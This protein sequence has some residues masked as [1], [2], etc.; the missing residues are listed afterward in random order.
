MNCA[1]SKNLLLDVLYE[2]ASSSVRKSV[3]THLTFCP[4]CRQEMS[5]VVE[6]RSIF[7]KLPS[8]EPA[9]HLLENVLAL[10]RIIFPVREMRKEGGWSRFLQIFSVFGL[11]P[12]PLT[13]AGG[14]VLAMIVLFDS[15]RSPLSI[16][17]E[18]KRANF[19]V[20]EGPSGLFVADEAALR[21]RVLANPFEIENPTF[22]LKYPS[23]VGS[24]GNV[25]SNFNGM[26]LE[27]DGSVADLETLF[28]QRRKM[29]VEADADSLMMRG[30]RLKSMGRV[31]MALKDF[32]TI[33]HFYPDFSKAISSCTGRNAMLFSGSTIRPW[34]VSL[35]MPKNI[36]T[37]PPSF[38][39]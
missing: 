33:Y 31:D 10:A 39:R 27:D 24:Q 14:M 8:L 21:E 23:P 22:D 11:R 19:S 9:P 3:E 28:S 13:I 6:I 20:R 36:P 35:F 17:P 5:Q 32:E 18:G 16:A 38:N 15:A 1:E 25:P 29:L 34:K 4:S 30:R 12:V 2:E 26:M 37:K 7:N